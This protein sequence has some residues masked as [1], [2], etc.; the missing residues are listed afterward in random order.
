MVPLAMKGTTKPVITA[1]SVMLVTVFR[2]PPG[3]MATTWK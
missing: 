3:N 2:S 1:A